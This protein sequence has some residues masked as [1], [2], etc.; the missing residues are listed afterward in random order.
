[1]SIGV[2]STLTTKMTRTMKKL[3][4]PRPLKSTSGSIHTRNSVV[5]LKINSGIFYL[6]SVTVCAYELQSERYCS[7]FGL[8]MTQ[9]VL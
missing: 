4:V 8:P 3:E 2:M 7:P 6:Y 1:M 5:D 9:K